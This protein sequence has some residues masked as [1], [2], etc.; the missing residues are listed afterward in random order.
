MESFEQ[1]KKMII[2]IREKK[3]KKAKG[4]TLIEMSMA[5]FLFVVIVSVISI[6]NI[7]VSQSSMRAQQMYTGTDMMRLGLEK[8]WREMKYGS[9]F[10]V[11]AQ[12]VAFKDRNC[13]D[14]S[15]FLDGTTGEL[16]YSVA[17]NE[18]ALNDPSVLNIS[19]FN[20]RAIISPVLDE[21]K[22]EIVDTASLISLSIMQSATQST[23]MPVILNISVAPVQSSFPNQ[24]CQP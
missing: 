2:R 8:I 18:T 23:S 20:A 11:S 1:L 6:S 16:K 12:S 9:N 13:Q 7:R 24:P 19:Q 10:T 4:F 17:G 22:A 5:M 15:L 3:P 14:A 21:A